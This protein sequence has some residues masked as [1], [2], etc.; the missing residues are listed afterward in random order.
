VKLL[1]EINTSVSFLTHEANELINYDES[2]T[3]VND[4]VLENMAWKGLI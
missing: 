3:Q 2:V 1:L 4:F